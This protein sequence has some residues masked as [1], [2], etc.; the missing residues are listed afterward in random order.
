[1]FAIDFSIRRD[2]EAEVTRWVNQVIKKDEPGAPDPVEVA[3][4]RTLE[5]GRRSAFLRIT[6]R[7]ELHSKLQAEM[8]EGLLA[9]EQ[10]DLVRTVQRNPGP[11]RLLPTSC[12]FQ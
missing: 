4:L 6:N 11:I 2:A 9:F 5:P 3:F 12:A 7:S 8:R 1:M 10:T